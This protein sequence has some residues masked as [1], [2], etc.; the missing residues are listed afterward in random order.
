MGKK[1]L[2][3]SAK[4]VRRALDINRISE[5]IL[6]NIKAMPEF[7]KA[8]NVLLY[9]PVASEINLLELCAE[10]KKFYLPRVRGGELL[11]CPYDCSVRL[12]KSSFN[13][14]EP[15]SASVSPTTID[16]AIIPCLM[17]DRQKFRLGYGGGFYDRFLPSLS[18]DCVK[19]APVAAELLVEKLPVEGFD[20]PVD[21]VVT[22][23][24]IF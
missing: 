21:F 24:E 10:N 19:I 22:Q 4:E 13:I 20:I 14:L 11:V 9:Y 23:N 2:R 12:E 5:A 6:L 16:F 7:K 17:V 8:E 3:K 15:C 1:N 18:P